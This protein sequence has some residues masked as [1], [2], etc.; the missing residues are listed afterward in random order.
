MLPFVAVALDQANLDRVVSKMEQ[1]I[2]ELASQVEALYQERCDTE[3][4]ARCTQ[5][6]YHECQS[7]LPTQ[8]CL[9]GEDL[10]LE[11]CGDGMTCSSLWDLRSSTFRVPINLLDD[12]SEILVSREEVIE[13]VCFSQG[14]DPYWNQKRAADEVFWEELGLRPPQAFFG[15][16]SGAFR[17]HPG[18]TYSTCG[19]Y[20]PRKRPW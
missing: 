11:A 5:G 18:R 16:E 1:D 20:D 19:T 6:N 7:E 3:L 4:L 10:V 13:G 14:L 15:G 2:L 12:P 8:Q 9:G 17:I